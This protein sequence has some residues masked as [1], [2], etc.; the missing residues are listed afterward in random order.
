MCHQ[1]ITYT[2][3][4]EERDACILS[5]SHCLCLLS[6]RTHTHTRWQWTTMLKFEVVSKRA[7]RMRMR[8]GCERVSE[9]MDARCICHRYC[10]TQNVLLKSELPNAYKTSSLMQMQKQFKRS[11]LRKFIHVFLLAMWNQTVAARYKW[12]QMLAPEFRAEP[13]FRWIPFFKY[14][15][16][17]SRNQ[18]NRTK[19]TKNQPNRTN[20]TH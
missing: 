11:F 2:E 13:P 10:K 8:N 15:L 19:P 18:P 20:A 4:E 3:R 17:R 14:I 1:W 5:P 7:Q 12:L 16:H 6:N 9:R